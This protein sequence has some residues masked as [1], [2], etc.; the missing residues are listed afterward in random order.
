MLRVDPRARLRLAE[1]IENL[2]DRIA[3]THGNGWLGE[4]QG[5]QVS[6]DAAAGKMTALNRAKRR[7]GGP[8]LRH[9]ATKS[10]QLSANAV[11]SGPTARGRTPPGVRQTL[12][13]ASDTSATQC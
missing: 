13:R 3:D 11:A 10:P 8:V 6:L 9:P 5:L 4:M 7:T 1:I 12:Q 2:R